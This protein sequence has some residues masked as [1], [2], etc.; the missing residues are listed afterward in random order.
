MQYFGNSANITETVIETT[1]AT[2]TVQSSTTNKIQTWTSQQ[3]SLLK[4]NSPK[5]DPSDPTPLL[6]DKISSLPVGS[7]RRQSAEN[8]KAT[9]DGTAENI[10]N[11]MD[12]LTRESYKEVKR[13]TKQSYMLQK[14]IR[15][16][17]PTNNNL[18]GIEEGR[19]VSN[20]QDWR[21]YFINAT[22]PI[23]DAIGS[24]ADTDY[25][26]MK[27]AG[28]AVAFLPLAAA[29]LTDKIS[30]EIAD[31]AEGSYKLNQLSL[32]QHL[33]SKVVGCVRQLSTALDSI[34]SVPFDIMSDVYNGLMMLIDEIANLIDGVINQIM[35]WI[36]GIL[37]GL[38]D[39]IFPPDL[40]ES[41]MEPIREIAAE[42]GDLF[43][44]LGAFPAVTAIANI[45]SNISGN[46]FSILKGAVDI[47]NVL[48]SGSRAASYLGGFSGADINCIEDQLTLRQ[49]RKFS[50]TSKYK[51]PLIIG[52]ILGF[53]VN[54]GIG[55]FASMIK[56]GISNMLGGFINNIRNIRDLIG[57]I[58]PA[59]I[60]YVLKF[61]L[62]K[63]C[64]L[65]MVGNRGYS[66]GDLFKSLRDNSFSKAL[67]TYTTHYA[68]LAPLFG[69]EHVDK[70][71]YAGESSVGL[72]ENSRFV[73]GAQVH[74]GIP[75]TGP[76]GSVFYK[77]FGLFQGSNAR[78]NKTY[79]STATA[80]G[81][82]NTANQGTVVNSSMSYLEQTTVLN[83]TAS[84]YNQTIIPST[85]TLQF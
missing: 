24:H 39:T 14:E 85:P 77:P 53:V 37:G 21:P 34:L 57:N 25:S 27:D 79:N 41:I 4:R 80:V 82:L 68:I 43:G 71:S 76:G 36:M 66:I 72:F 56:G 6:I 58:L 5:E 8:I 64:G 61:L 13:I 40:L 78:Y 52:Q 19:M 74:K 42:V 7:A 12:S 22:R 38:V 54:N 3:V 15:Q 65:G 1:T 67:Q 59:A 26:I 44:L 48:R 49:T 17:L 84:S 10:G 60:G 16:P 47:Y 63:L 46:F 73:L 29:S 11:G 35:G 31:Q 33:P 70:Y 32:L 23:S 28:G 20:V 51:K 75:L 2:E 55:N 62:H 18:F 50:S 30:I 45:V 69:K 9:L 83:K 81:N